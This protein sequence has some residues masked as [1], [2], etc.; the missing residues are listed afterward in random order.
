MF[1]LD[2][3][4]AIEFGDGGLRIDFGDGDVNMYL[5]RDGHFSCR[6]PHPSWYPLLPEEV[7][8]RRWLSQPKLRHVAKP[9]IAGRQSRR[10]PRIARFPTLTLAWWAAQIPS[11]RLSGPKPNAPQRVAGLGLFTLNLPPRLI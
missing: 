10:P 11:I 6:S 2:A 5:V 7:L 4:S 1:A 3:I 9:A 8:Q